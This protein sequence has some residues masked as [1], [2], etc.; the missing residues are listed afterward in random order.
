[1]HV[2]AAAGTKS[3]G[4]LYAGLLDEYQSSAGTTGWIPGLAMFLIMG[5]GKRLIVEETPAIIQK[6][7]S[8][9]I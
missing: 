1:M 5:L 4:V 6:G 3:F 2:F 9:T 7:Q 8:N